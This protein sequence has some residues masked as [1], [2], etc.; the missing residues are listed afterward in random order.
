M[1]EHLFYTQVVAGSTPVGTMNEGVAQ[2]EEHQ[3]STLKVVG[4]SPTILA[5]GLGVMVTRDPC[6]VVIGVRLP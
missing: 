6:T 4:S 5:R 3:A 1:V 2:M